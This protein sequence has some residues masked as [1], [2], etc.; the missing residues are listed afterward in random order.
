MGGET[1][2]N[3]YTL[4]RGYFYWQNPLQL[5]AAAFISGDI[6]CVAYDAPIYGKDNS[7]YGSLGG[8]HTFFDDRLKAKLSLTYSQDPYFD[9]AVGALM[10]ILIQF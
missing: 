1:P 4:Y 7:L 10:T 5:S 3:I 2:E 9:S 6:M 8:G